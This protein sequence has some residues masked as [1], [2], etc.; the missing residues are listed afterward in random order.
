[1][2]INWYPGHMKKTKDL[3]QENLKLVNIVIEVID[4]RIPISSKNPDFDNLFR[5]K[6][7]LIVLN[8][9]D[10]ADPNLNKAW[11]AYYK[12][13][14]WAVVLYNSTNNKELR[15]LDN[16]IAEASKEI[17]ERY[18]KRGLLNRTIKAMIV[19]IPN[20]GKS[21]L[22]NSLA[23]RKSA[24]TGNMP[25][26]TKGKQWIR[27]T[28]NIDLLDTPG[29]LWP[30]FDDDKLALNLA[31]TGAIKDE[32][33]ILEEISLKFV[34]KMIELNKVDAI[35]EKY[36]IEQGEKPLDILDNIA[37][38]KGFLLNKT[39]IDYLRVANL[40]FNDFRNGKLGNI[41]LEKPEDYHSG[42]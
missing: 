11:E 29:I 31:F 34:E 16:A 25:G 15:K 38:K 14:G 39:E 20:V 28:G 24:K 12:S 35:L 3:L 9:Y 7:R 36:D 18:K 32:V 5:D 2:N 42:V 26:V 10:L 8:K 40:L 27:L 21:T 30:K 4:A 13:K 23:K 1:M 17:V 22:I 33:I 41:T 19:G 6:K 37:Y